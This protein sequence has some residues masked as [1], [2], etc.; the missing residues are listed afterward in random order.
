[1]NMKYI[2]FRTFKETSDLI[3][4]IAE[5]ALFSLEDNSCCC[6]QIFELFHPFK[7]TLINLYTMR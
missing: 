5:Q 3:I 7:E 6:S 4:L 1:M 2:I